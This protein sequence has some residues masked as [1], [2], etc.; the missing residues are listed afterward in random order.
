M[1]GKDPCDIFLYGF[2]AFESKSMIGPGV[3]STS[4]FLQVLGS[5]DEGSNQ[6]ILPLPAVAQIGED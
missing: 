2:L 4:L 5:S 1:K 3:T 6:V